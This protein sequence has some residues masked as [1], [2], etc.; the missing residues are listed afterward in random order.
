MVSR[1]SAMTFDV[2]ET[3]MTLEPRAARFERAGLP[4]S[5]LGAW[6]MR[7]LLLGMELS[8]AGDYVPFPQVAAEV[9][10]AIGGYR[11]SHN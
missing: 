5:A 6:F 11:R 7:L 8:A 4:A 2:V 1:P 10:R 9:L 3:L